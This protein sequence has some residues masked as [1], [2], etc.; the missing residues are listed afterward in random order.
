[1]TE[2]FNMDDIWVHNESESEWNICH[3]AV[4]GLAVRHRIFES[5]VLSFDKNEFLKLF[6]KK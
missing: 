5:Q 3:L 2:F 6:T 4:Y 1:M